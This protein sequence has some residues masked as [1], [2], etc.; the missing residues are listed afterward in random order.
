MDE[1]S[2]ETCTK[3]PTLLAGIA[4]LLCEMLH[5]SLLHC[6]YVPC[7][8]KRPAYAFSVHRHFEHT[9]GRH[10]I[11]DATDSVYMPAD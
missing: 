7:R 9:T 8:T 3:F 4:A 6:R 1:I 10:V 5:S 11:D 2:N